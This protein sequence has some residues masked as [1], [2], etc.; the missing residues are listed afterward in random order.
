MCI[1]ICH[2]GVR[3]PRYDEWGDPVG[4]EGAFRAIASYCPYHNVRPQAYPDML[5][6]GSLRD[7]RVQ[8]WHPAK[9]AARLREANTGDSRILLR[10]DMEGGHFNHGLDEEAL[11]CAFLQQAVAARCGW[12]AT[13]EDG[14]TPWLF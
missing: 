9:L 10:T 1:L 2:P 14:G 3:R 6:T 11:D 8:Y 12:G 7:E 13:G 5:L 4:D